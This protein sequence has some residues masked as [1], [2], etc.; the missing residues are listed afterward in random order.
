[1]A[2]A[3]DN[4]KN[5]EEIREELRA[6]YEANMQEELQAYRQALKS[7]YGELGELDPDD[8]ATVLRVRSRLL[9][10]VPDAATTMKQLINFADSEAVR[11]NLSKFVF[12]EAMGRAKSEAEKDSLADLLK[13][14]AKKD[15]D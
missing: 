9:Q 2:K 14:V 6:E 12:Q 15:D 13:A 3:P 5:E 11:A 7:E 8:P 1:M 10:L 4:G